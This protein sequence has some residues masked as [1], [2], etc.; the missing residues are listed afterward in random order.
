MKFCG[1]CGRPLAVADRDEGSQRR[2]VTV[3]FCDMVGS[4]NLVDSLDPED[5][6]EILAAYQQTCEAAVQRYDGFSAQWAG[7]GL[8]AY[9]GYPQAHEDQAQRAVHAGLQIVAEIEQCSARL[10]V[11]LQVRVGLHSG[12]VVTG[13]VGTGGARLERAVVG[14]TPH[15]AAR[16]QSLAAPGTVVVS[17]AV[18]E[19]V[20]RHFVLEPLGEH[21]LRGVARPVGVHRAL[22]ATGVVGRLDV[23]G[24]R[25]LK[26]MVGRDAEFTQ[27]ETAWGRA[28]GGRGAIVH[29]PGEAGIGKSRLVRA[30][31]ETVGG[32]HV[33]QCS[34]HHGSTSLY[35]VIQYLERRLG[36]ERSEPPERQVGAL[37]RS[38]LDVGLDPGTTVPFLAELLGVDT[39]ERTELAPIDARTATMRAIEALLAADAAV[40]PLLLVVEDL[41]WADPTTIE[42][43]GRLATEL[44][45]HRVLCVATYRREF[46]PQWAADRTI[47]LGPL[48]QADV[49]AMVAASGLDTDLSGADGVPLF[50]EELLKLL[51]LQDHRD[52]D[53]STAT[54]VP[55]TLQGLLTQRLERLPEYSDVIDVAAVL[56]REFE[57]E[58]IA[59][60]VPL[61]GAIAKLVEHEVIRPVDGFTTRFEFTHALLQDAAY[62]RLLRRR[63][64][65]LHGQVAALLTTRFEALAERE[66]E[67]VAHHWRRAG[68]PGKSVPFWQAAGERAIARAAFVEAA[69]HFRSGLD[70]LEQAGADAGDRSELLIHLGASL[71]AGIGYAAPGVDEAYAE[72]RRL[73]VGH[74]LAFVLRGQWAFHLLRA[75]Y[76]TAEGYA[77][78]QLELAERTGDAALLADGHYGRGMVHLYRGEFEL[79]RSHLTESYD[80]YTPRAPTDWLSQAE[81][82]TGVAAL[83]YNSSV[84]WNLG[85]AQESLWRSDLSLELAEQ[86]GGPVTRAQAWGMRALLHLARVEPTEF[87]RWTERTRAHS[88]DHNVG[89]WRALASLLDGALQAR[90]GKLEAG[91]ALVDGALA[92]YQRSGSRLGLS[93]FYVLQA[94][95]RLLSGNHAGAFASLEAAEEHTVSTGERYTEAELH[96]FKGRLLMAQPHPDVEAATAAFEQ[97]VAAAHRQHATLLELRAATT[98]ALHQRQTGAPATALERVAQ[99]SDRLSAHSALADLVQARGLLDQPV[100][101]R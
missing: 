59:A 7:D 93:R 85:E 23:V 79:A 41:H 28:A 58:P 74:R 99:L 61:D 31:T 43:L 17:D 66:P 12:L 1:E 51:A 69:D 82:D 34:S 87:A 68:E 26:P 40:D 36:L 6:R 47:A 20:D 42:L 18:R 81:G 94:D 15:I 39:G 70:A 49:R 4:T 10:N 78:D 2:H 24:P 100:A 92:A 19:L 62:T 53:D 71:Q 46:E 91:C 27:L 45:R 88:V 11:P 89:Y 98:L 101:A 90:A 60:L 13:E 65:A 25:A 38:V 77:N 32:A 5:F 22:R 9:F 48:T 64:R 44:P 73:G 84:L 30:L 86:V 16:L 33:W 97:A 29:I 35:P 55:P 50:I 83:A 56:G 37:T 80:R 52:R 63:R 8:L 57:V 96:R 21:A 75:E 54:L 14:T 67:I 95:L 76:G 3:M 72:A